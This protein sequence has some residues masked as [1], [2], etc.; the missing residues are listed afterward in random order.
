M[1]LPQETLPRKSK[2]DILPRTPDEIMQPSRIGMFFPHR[3]SFMRVLSRELHRECAAVER[4]VW[5]MDAD[6]FGLAV[7][8]VALGGNPYSLVAFSNY[9]DPER[10]TDRVIAEAWD[11]TFALFDGIPDSGDLQRLEANVPKQESATI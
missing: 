2:L 9:L 1:S 4:S 11:T 7:Y 3:L 5:R 8:T 10:R 6:G